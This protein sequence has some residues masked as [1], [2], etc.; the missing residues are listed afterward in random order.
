T[1]LVLQGRNLVL[2]AITLAL[3]FLHK[4]LYV[5]A[6]EGTLYPVQNIFFIGYDH[7]NLVAGLSSFSS[8]VHQYLEILQ[9]LQDHSVLAID[10]I[11]NSTGSEE[12]SAL[13]F[14]LFE[15]MQAKAKIKL[16]VST[17]HQLLKTLIYED[18]RFLSAHM[19]FDLE[20]NSPTYKLITGTP[21][22]SFAFNIFEKVT[23]MRN[24]K[25]DIPTNAKALMQTS[26]QLYEKL[27]ENVSS[28]EHLLNKQL[29]EVNSLNNELQNQK[30]ASQGVLRL[31]KEKAYH[32]YEKKLKKV[33]DEAIALKEQQ[34]AHP[35]WGVKAIRSKT[36][37]IASELKTLSPRAENTALVEYASVD[38]IE[39]GKIYFSKHLGCEVLVLQINHR[40]REAQVSANQ[41]QAGPRITHPLDQLFLSKN[42]SAKRCE[43]KIQFSRQEASHIEVNARGLRLPDFEA[44]VEDGLTALLLD[45]IPYL[46]IIH[47]HG[48][49]ILKKYLRD[50]LQRDD[51]FIYEIPDAN[52]GATTVRKA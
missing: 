6:R 35:E 29:G 12:A 48:E 19:A 52:D 51:R 1:P 32:E 17:H 43:M 15:E 50:R 22:P 31:E 47:G 36:Y 9:N 25:T 3:L 38:L 20:N 46:S 8:E 14:A 27:L 13:A 18:G 23:E 4:G 7:Q 34:N 33:L 21:G 11:F 26:K 49:G 40:K 37:E 28:K 5:P 16:L 30:M 45:E 39:E 24:W 44:L 2:K 41:S 10:E 42:T